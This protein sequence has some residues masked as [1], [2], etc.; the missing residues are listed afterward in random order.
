M[1]FPPLDGFCLGMPQHPDSSA[2]GNILDVTFTFDD[3]VAWLLIGIW[4]QFEQI[5]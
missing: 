4:G 3:C 2:M 1:Q 5:I